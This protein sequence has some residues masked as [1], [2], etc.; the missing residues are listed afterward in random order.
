MKKL[1]WTALVTAVSTAAARLAVRALV[2]MWRQVT[3]ENPP[4]TSRWA[5]FLVGKTTKAVT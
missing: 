5:Q 3:K 1:A 2:R 4:P